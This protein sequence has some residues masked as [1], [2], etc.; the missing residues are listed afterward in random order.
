M[1]SL[2]TILF[3]VFCF[4]MA[5]T[6]K[7]ERVDMLKSGAKADGK[8][9]N[10]T[11][12]NHTVDRLSQAG[13]GTLFFPAGTYLTGAIRLK[14]N[15]TLELEAGA[16]LLF[17]DNFDDYLPFMEVRHEGVMMKSFSPLISAMD[18]EN[19]TIKGEGTLDGQGKAWWTE[20]F[21]IYVD[22]E[23]NG[24]RELNKY[25]P[26]WERENDVEA[27]Y[28]ETNE[29]WHGTLK[30]RF[31]RPPFIQPVRCRRVRIE[32]V[33]I[34]NSPFW[35]VN[36]EFCDNVVVTGVTIHNVPSPNT[37]GINPE[38]CRNVHIS[39]CHISVGDDCITL[40]SGR[41]A[42]ARR[43]GV[44]C[45][46][47]TITNCTMLSGHGGVVIGSEMSGSVRKVTISNCVFDGTDR[48]IRI[49][50]TRGRGGVVED[51][52]VSNIIM[53]NIKREAVVLNLKYSK[54]PVEPMSERTPL[55]RDISISGLTAVGV[56]TPVKIVGLEEAP[57]TDIILRDINV[58]NAREKCIF[59]NCERIRLT[60]V[61]V[62][63]KEVRLEE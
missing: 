58:K 3:S 2:R 60:D 55:F 8:T 29:D 19:I 13:G 44:P 32:G 26:L 52:R 20:F 4:G 56:K 34:I 41:D 10:T 24:M 37:D 23:K 5:I 59:E 63:G 25:Q 11:L 54:M 51:I 36:P 38:S 30:R 50:S 7:A 21:R 45:E 16:T 18:A 48:G 43:L 6:L 12:I 46:N 42:Q 31:F 33:K 1:E 53:S 27:L 62:N 40:K 17:S 14:S 9:L 22:L 15:I 49:K 39:D 61:I 57:V 35:T 47:I 28:A